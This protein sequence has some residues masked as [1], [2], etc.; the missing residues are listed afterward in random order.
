MGI[1]NP[2]HL[3]FIAAVALIVLGPRRLPDLARSLGNGLREFREAMSQSSER[4]DDHHQ[5]PAPAAPPPPAPV[6]APPPA[7]APPAAYSGPEI[8][9]PEA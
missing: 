1:E 3:I 8:S 2:V 4:H 9:P 5:A 6:Q 7:A